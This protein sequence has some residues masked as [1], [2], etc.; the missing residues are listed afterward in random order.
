MIGSKAADRLF[1][2]GA[3]AVLSEE[4]RASGW[5]NVIVIGTKGDV[6]EMAGMMP[7]NKVLR[8]LLKR[9]LVALD[10]PRTVSS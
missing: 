6:A 4:L 8:K 1:F 7:T 2:E 5:E 9:A 10:A 3:V